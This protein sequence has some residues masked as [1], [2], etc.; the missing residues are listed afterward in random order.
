MAVQDTEVLRVL[1]HERGRDALDIRIELESRKR[2]K[3]RD[4]A[5][6]FGFFQFTPTFMIPTDDEVVASLEAL[7][8]V[9]KARID[10][11]RNA[12]EFLRV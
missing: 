2:R 9:G 10:S 6:Q 7:R 1:H 11:S 3:A 4:N 12:A 5:V 8:S